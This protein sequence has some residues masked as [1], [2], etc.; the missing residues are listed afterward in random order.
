MFACITLF[1]IMFFLY[2]TLVYWCMMVHPFCPSFIM[3]VPLLIGF[4]WIAMVQQLLHNAYICFQT[5][6]G[7]IFNVNLAFYAKLYL[8]D[9]AYS[10]IMQMK[11]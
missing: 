4:G 10:N 1:L 8:V 3:L 7:H 9:N 6:Y 2:L 11:T 5:D